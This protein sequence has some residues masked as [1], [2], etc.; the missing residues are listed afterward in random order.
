M[1]SFLCFLL[2]TFYCT[3][4]LFTFRTIFWDKGKL[5]FLYL[6]PLPSCPPRNWQ[7]RSGRVLPSIDF[8]DPSAEIRA[9]MPR[10]PIAA[11]L[12]AAL[13]AEDDYWWSTGTSHESGS[14]RLSSPG[15]LPSSGS[16]SDVDADSDCIQTGLCRT[17]STQPPSPPDSLRSIPGPVHVL[18]TQVLP[19]EDPSGPPRKKRR[20]KKT[21]R[22]LESRKER[23][24]DERRNAPPTARTPQAH[25]IKLHEAS[26][27]VLEAALAILNALP[28]TTTVY[29][30]KRV[31]VLKEGQVWTRAD[32]QQAGFHE[33]HWDGRCVFSSNDVCCH[34]HRTPLAPHMLF[35]TMRDG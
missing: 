14:P 1:I 26:P 34:S 12:E 24:Q 30:G 8:L 7:L 6:N 2:Q 25:L 16:S 13:Q 29:T 17:L 22:D 15:S 32:L 35:W 27:E 20:R 9:L 19:I 5:L 4:A 10:I 3:D 28:V 33:F 31:P 23:R 21:A 18:P 11:P